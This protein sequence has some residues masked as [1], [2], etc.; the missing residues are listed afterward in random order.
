LSKG[1]HEFAQA[2]FLYL[3]LMIR[4]RSGL[5]W[6][7]RR[8]RR[9]LV[10]RHS[11]WFDGSETVMVAKHL[12]FVLFLLA[13]QPGINVGRCG[14]HNVPQCGDRDRVMSPEHVFLNIPPNR[15]VVAKP[16]LIVQ[17]N[18]PGGRWGS[19]RSRHAN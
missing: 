5:H 16:A 1:I 10:F 6:V 7:L 14:D 8:H 17:N 9:W 15:L 4:W 18:T 11:R 13:R 19:L 3:F 12:P 2:G